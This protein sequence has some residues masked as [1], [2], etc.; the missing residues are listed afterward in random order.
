MKMFPTCVFCLRLTLVLYAVFFVESLLS[1][2]DNEEEPPS[3]KHK[4]VSLLI[5]N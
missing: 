1:N 3:P 2:S 5:D 4:Q